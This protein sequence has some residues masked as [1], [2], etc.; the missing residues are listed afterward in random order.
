METNKIKELE[1]RVENL[2]NLI[3]DFYKV[4]NYALVF[5]TYDEMISNAIIL[6]N[7]YNNEISELKFQ[8]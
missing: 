6:I 1:E 2:K 3:D 4:K 8:Y 5:L 7:K